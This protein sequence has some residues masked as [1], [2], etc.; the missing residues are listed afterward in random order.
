MP[1]SRKWKLFWWTLPAVVV[2]LVVAAVILL[3]WFWSLRAAADFQEGEYESAEASYRRQ[4]AVSEVF[5]EPW[6]AIY[7][8]GTTQ[9]ADGRYEEANEV[10]ARALERVPPAAEGPDGLKDPDSPECIVRTN[11]SLTHEGMGDE[12][13]AAGDLEEAIEQYRQAL[14]VI[15]S[16]TSDGQSAAEQEERP[17]PQDEWRPDL[18]EQRQW[19]KM[20]SAEE[21]QEQENEPGSEPPSEPEPTQDPEDPRITELEERNQSAQPTTNTDGQGFG[22]GQNW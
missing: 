3:L 17:E 5:P 13:R 20:Q 7:N 4:A 22:G 14:D 21:E 8:E 12:L 15:G 10:L 11:L 2:L 19:D 1:R 6:K 9:L 18:D 16:C